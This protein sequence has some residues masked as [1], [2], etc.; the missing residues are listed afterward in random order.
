[1]PYF[2]F[3]IARFFVLL[4]ATC[5]DGTH[6]VKNVATA[7]TRS[8]KEENGERDEEA[9]P[10]FEEKSDIV[11]FFLLLLFFLFSRGWCATSSEMALRED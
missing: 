2:S 1:M 11:F 9:R 3:K 10:R 8:E 6:I 7:R 5:L 4:A